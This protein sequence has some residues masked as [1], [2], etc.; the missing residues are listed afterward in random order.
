M[1]NLVMNYINHFFISISSFQHVFYIQIMKSYIR[2]F[3]IL[4]ILLFSSKVATAQYVSIPDTNFRSY[5]ITYYPTCMNGSLMD[6][7]CS[8]IINAAGMDVSNRNIS[9]LTGIQYFDKLTYLD[10][11]G[12]NLTTLPILPKGLYRLYCSRNQLTTFTSLPLTI[13]ELI[14]QGNQL[15]SLPPIPSMQSLYCDGNKLTLLPTLP[16]TLITLACNS[17]QLSSL[18]PLPPNLKYLYC[19]NNKLVGLPLIPPN[20][21][22]I[23]TA[24]NQITV[25][26]ALPASLLHLDCR[27]N[28]LQTLPALPSAL[29]FISCSHNQI[30]SLPALPASLI[31]FYCDHNQI[32]SLPDLP[33]PLQTLECNKNFLNCLPFLPHDITSLKADSN[34]IVC[35][36]NIP[37]SYINSNIGKAICNDFNNLNGCTIFPQIS[38]TVFFDANSNSIKEIG[39]NGFQI[40]TIEIQPGNYLVSTDTNGFYALNVDTGNY[41]ISINPNNYTYYN[42]IPSGNTASFTSYGQI[43]SLNNFAMKPN[44]NLNDLQIS[45]TLNGQPRAD[46]TI[47]YYISYKNSGTTSRSGTIKLTYDHNLTFVGTDPLFVNHSGDTLSWNYSDLLPGQQ[48]NVI[49]FF[50]LPATIAIGSILKLKADITPLIGD[51]TPLNN[52]DSIVNYVVSSHDPNFKEVLPSFDISTSDV[53]NQIPFTYTV[54]FQNTGTDTAFTVVI[55]DTISSHLEFYEIETIASS[56]HYTFKMKDGISIWTFKN[57]LLPDS[58]TNEP[59]SHGFVKY[60]LK[61]KNSLVIGDNIKNTAHIYFDYNAPVNTNTTSNKVAGALGILNKP[62]INNLFSVFPNPTKGNVTI[63]SLVNPIECSKIT[64]QRVDGEIIQTYEK[65]NLTCPFNLDLKNETK[66]IYI[67]QIFYDKY[68]ATKK[69]V[70][71]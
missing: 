38:G 54:H 34:H 48:D 16:N 32:T 26:P 29:P 24:F 22:R 44:S 20:L 18:P 3:F 2:I 33:Y 7:T 36:P 69:L 55:K 52:R 59:L 45:I 6:T 5:L 56:H 28:Q 13:W 19:Q 14:C 35:L 25:L 65:V 4:S 10:C 41:S 46:D 70:I 40:A 71:E 42:I 64:V 9:D 11:T 39:E 68:A 51:N 47:S 43:D 66:G 1:I 53:S 37:N 63:Q 62:I 31:N 27:Y 57:I 23:E 12:N 49:A 67:I 8:G 58:L 60:K 15:T 30:T 61:P 50:S 17:N 21:E